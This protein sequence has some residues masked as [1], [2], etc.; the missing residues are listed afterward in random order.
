MA[1]G[2]IIAMVVF[3]LVALS[4][5]ISAA[6]DLH[7]L[8]S[9]DP[10]INA[11]QRSLTEWTL[12]PV[13]RAAYLKRFK[14]AAMDFDYDKYRKMYSHPELTDFEIVQNF[15]SENMNTEG[16]EEFRDALAKLLIMNTNIRDGLVR[17]KLIVEDIMMKDLTCPLSYQP[18]NYLK[19]YIREYNI[20][21]RIDNLVGHHV[22]I[23]NDLRHMKPDPTPQGEWTVS[24]HSMMAEQTEMEGPKK[25]KDAQQEALGSLGVT[26]SVVFG[27][28]VAF[29]AYALMNYSHNWEP[30]YV[31]LLGFLLS[32][33]LLV[34]AFR[35]FPFGMLDFADMW[36]RIKHMPS[37][38]GIPERKLRK[39]LE[40]E[41]MK[42]LDGNSNDNKK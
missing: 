11:K 17:E 34:L 40:D 3:V 10:T 16:H 5:P 18:V 6:K 23:P 9:R 35:I 7:T 4:I 22:E 27:V 20:Q 24:A 36:A 42:K 13:E 26:T 38:T 41:E 29:T 19:D 8:N 15:V 28:C 33:G 1:I 32:I 37:Y 14:N 21:T 25:H 2:G 31:S 12:K 30:W 39:K